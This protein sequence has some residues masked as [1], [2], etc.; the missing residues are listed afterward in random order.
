[1]ATRGVLLRRG[2]WRCRGDQHP[3]T[4]LIHQI[5][6]EPVARQIQ[7]CVQ[8]GDGPPHG[9]PDG[10]NPDLA[11]GEALFMAFSGASVRLPSGSM[12]IPA[13]TGSGGRDSWNDGDSYDSVMIAPPRG[14]PVAS[15][16]AAGPATDTVRDQSA[17]RA[18]ADR[19]EAG[20]LTGAW[21]WCDRPRGRQRRTSAGPIRSIGRSPSQGRTCRRSRLSV[22][23]RVLG[24]RSGSVE[25]SSHTHHR[26]NGSR[27]RRRP[28]QIPRRSSRRFSGGR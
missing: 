11:I 23:A 25:Y 4:C 16:L 20:P 21:A 6:V 24:L 27:P 7:P 22:M 10:D 18:P 14:W 17:R 1:M 13:V 15:H 19:T 2:S 5:H 3:L 9:A 26:L 8:H 28:C 12:M